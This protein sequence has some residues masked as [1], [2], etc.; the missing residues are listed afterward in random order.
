MKVRLLEPNMS[1]MKIYSKTGQK[2]FYP[3]ILIEHYPGKNNN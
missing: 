2:A 1:L 3:N